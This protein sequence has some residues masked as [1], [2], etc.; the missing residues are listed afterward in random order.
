VLRSVNP[1][2][3][4][5]ESRYGSFV[6]PHPLQ[7]TCVDGTEGQKQMPEVPHLAVGA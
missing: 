5:F 4:L 7:H 1:K 6:R 3:R 2:T